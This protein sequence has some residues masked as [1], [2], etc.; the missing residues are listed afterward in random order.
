MS[1]LDKRRLMPACS[2]AATMASRLG[3]QHPNGVEIGVVNQLVAQRLQTFG[4]DGGVAPLTR[5]AMRLR[6]S[7]PW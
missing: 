6:P 7:G 4:Q 5:R 3:R 2:A 1:S